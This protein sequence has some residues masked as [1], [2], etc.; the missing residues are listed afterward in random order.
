[1]LGLSLTPSL[2]LEQTR[3]YWVVCRAETDKLKA[4]EALTAGSVE[5]T[6]FGTIKPF[7]VCMNARQSGIQ[8]RKHQTAGIEVV[9]YRFDKIPVNKVAFE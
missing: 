6:L 9:C 2:R 1:M 3:N 5:I 4:Y 7:D 8:K